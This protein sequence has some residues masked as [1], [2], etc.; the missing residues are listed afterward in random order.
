MRTRWRVSCA[1]LTLSVLACGGKSA[2]ERVAEHDRVRVSWEQTA[3][4]VG[5][6]W[7]A[8]ALPDAYATRTL[9]RAG[10]ELQRESDALRKDG[11]PGEAR[12]RLRDSLAAARALA[13]SL[14]RAIRAR[15]RAAAARL[16]TLSPRPNTDSLLRQA[17][18]R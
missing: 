10:E 11:I 8:R 2:A 6:E 7:V 13:D 9:E 4:V 1:A 16:V 12:V 18:L 5:A 15:D 17:G 14:E 3:H